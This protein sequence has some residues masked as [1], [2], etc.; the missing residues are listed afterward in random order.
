MSFVTEMVERPQVS[1]RFLTSVGSSLETSD[2]ALAT[3]QA[4]SIL[5]VGSVS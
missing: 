5:S 2:A 3:G 1:G 4:V